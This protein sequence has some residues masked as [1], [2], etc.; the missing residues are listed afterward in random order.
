MCFRGAEHPHIPHS[1]WAAVKTLSARSLIHG[2]CHCIGV[3][4][5]PVFSFRYAATRTFIHRQRVTAQEQGLA[6]DMDMED[7]LIL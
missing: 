3:M 1:G 4:A 7:I 2:T 5:V 6:C